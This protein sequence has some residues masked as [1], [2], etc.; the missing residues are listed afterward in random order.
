MKRFLVVLALV[1][2]LMSLAV[3]CYAS[4]SS[5]EPTEESAV[6]EIEKSYIDGV[7]S[8][9]SRSVV[10]DGRRSVPSGLENADKAEIVKF[11]KENPEELKSSASLVDR[12]VALASKAAASWILTKTASG[13]G[14]YYYAQE[15]DTTCAVACARMCLRGVAGV[16]VTES[17]AASAMGV[18]PGK[19][20]ATVVDITDYLNLKQSKYTYDDKYSILSSLFHKNQYNAIKAGAPTVVG[21]TTS[22]SYWFYDTDGHAISCYAIKSDKSSYL[23]ADPLGG[24]EKEPSWRWYEK[25][26]SQLWK[27][28]SSRAGYVA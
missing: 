7:Q 23:I 21:I 24:W 26:A 10:S 9:G 8:D 18:T 27:A 16:T 5:I 12:D 28:Y 19:T 2:I 13:Y 1:A 25:S 22:S 15:S 20:G 3:P 11:F 14:F 17:A 4:S 6:A